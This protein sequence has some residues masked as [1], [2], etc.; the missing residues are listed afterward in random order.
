MYCEGFQVYALRLICAALTTRVFPVPFHEINMAFSTTCPVAG[1]RL[2]SSKKVVAPRRAA[3]Q[4][5]DLETL[6]PFE[7]TLCASKYPATVLQPV[8]AGPSVSGSGA[9]P[10]IAFGLVSC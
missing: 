9:A 4:V 3:V 8:L 6:F 1:A 10:C 2:V 7:A 5:T